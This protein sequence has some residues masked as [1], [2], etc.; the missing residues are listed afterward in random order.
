MQKRNKRE[1]A[2]K[3]KEKEEGECCVRRQPPS[4]PFDTEL[5]RT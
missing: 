2:K 1:K 3:K 5:L 4:F